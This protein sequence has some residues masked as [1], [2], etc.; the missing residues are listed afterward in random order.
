MLNIYIEDINFNNKEGKMIIKGEE[1]KAIDPTFEEEKEVILK[2][3]HQ[4][5]GGKEWVA[6]ILGKDTKY[7]YQ[8]EFLQPIHRDWSS[9]GKTGWTYYRLERGFTYEINEPW[10]KRRILELKLKEDYNV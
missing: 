3:N 6:K 8:R 1:A 9:S 5:S 10:N 4:P 2:I 7:G